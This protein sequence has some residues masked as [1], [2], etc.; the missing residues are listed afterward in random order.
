MSPCFF[1]FFQAEDGIR[2]RN[3]TGV[4]TCA[5]PISPEIVDPVGVAGLADVVEDGADLGPR[6]ALLDQGHH[7]HS[8]LPIPARRNSPPS[9]PVRNRPTIRISL[10]S[11]HSGCAKV[12]GRLR[13]NARWPSQAGP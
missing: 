7:A 8:G 11:D 2:D 10:N 5:L 4:Q 1:F 6:L 12:S 13:S 9:R 3:V